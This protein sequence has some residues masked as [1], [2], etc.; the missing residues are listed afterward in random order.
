[1]SIHKIT[2]INFKD[3]KHRMIRY[4]AVT[5]TIFTASHQATSR[6]P[7]TVTFRPLR[8]QTKQQTTCHSVDL[9]GTVRG[10]AAVLLRDVL[11]MPTLVAPV[12]FRFRGCP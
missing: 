2:K 12:P 11:Q 4:V 9:E 3:L 10:G 7:Q 1:M 6:E 8:P 5:I